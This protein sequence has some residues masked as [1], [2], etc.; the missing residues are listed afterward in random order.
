M[1]SRN[2][3]YNRGV[4]KRT[5]PTLGLDVYMYRDEPG[6]FRNAYGS[7]VAVEVAEG[8]GFNVK[9]LAKDRRRIE[10]MKVAA[11]KIEEQLLDEGDEIAKEVVKSRDGFHVVH[12]GLGR[13]NLEDPDGN[14]LNKVYL[15]K[16]QGLKLLDQM[17]SPEEDDDAETETSETQDEKEGERKVPKINFKSKKDKTAGK[18]EGGG[19]S[20]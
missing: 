6:I 2:I 5:H 4:I 20:K 15:S 12:I 14:V 1:A 17:T 7:E 10:L 8:C 16:E 18:E 13:Y 3:D 19:K 11:Q 9:A